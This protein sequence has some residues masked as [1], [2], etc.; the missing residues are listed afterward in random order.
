MIIID[1]NIFIRKRKKITSKR[2]D[3]VIGN[4]ANVSDDKSVG[5]NNAEV[6]RNFR[7]SNRVRFRVSVKGFFEMGFSGFS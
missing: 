4:G 5:N 3:N 6:E 7:R 1:S 2:N